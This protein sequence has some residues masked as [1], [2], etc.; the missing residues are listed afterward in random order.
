MAAKVIDLV[1]GNVTAGDLRRQ[2][3]PDKVPRSEQY[4]TVFGRA[5]DLDRIQA[6]L[7]QADFG[8]MVDLTDLEH[9]MLSLDPHLS[10]VVGKRTGWVGALDWVLDEAT[11]DNIDP[12]LATRIAADTRASIE[13]IPLFQRRLVDLAW[14][15]YDGRSALET[16]WDLAP[17]G[18]WSGKELA[19]IHP[20]RLSYGSRRELRLIDTFNRRGNFGDDG[21]ALEDFP[22]HFITY[23]PRLFNEYPEREGLAPRTLYWSFFKR[24]DWRMRMALTELFGIPWRIIETEKDATVNKEWLEEAADDAEALGE[25]TTMGLPPGAKLNIPNMGKQDGQLF[26][27]TSDDVNGEMSKLVL[28]NTGTTETD[29][30]NR[31]GMIIAKSEQ[32]VTMSGDAE[33]VSGAFQAG[34]VVPFVGLNYGMGAL[35]HAPTFRIKADTPRDQ[36]KEVERITQIVSLGI[37]VAEAE[38]REAGGARQVEEDEAFI[39][40]TGDGFKRVDPAAPPPPPPAAAPPPP[41]IEDDETLEEGGEDAAAKAAEDDLTGL[42]VQRRSLI[43]WITKR[44]GLPRSQAERAYLACEH[45]RYDELRRIPG[46]GTDSA[47]RILE[48][49][50]RVFVVSAEDGKLVPQNVALKLDAVAH[51]SANH[52]HELRV[53]DSDVESGTARSYDI[54]GAADHSHTVAIDEAGMEQ[55]K[56][57]EAITVTSTEGGEPAHVHEL[58]LVSVG[59]KTDQD[60]DDEPTGLSRVF[61]W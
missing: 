49:V 34:Y 42:E 16:H 17:G 20:R 30:G 52:G 41:P 35:D 53:G 3:I 21:F 45:G 59:A 61:T 2:L 1:N 22:G 8:L 10:G 46:L 29:Q 12:K 15:V 5:V 31:A 39:V 28:G 55:L 4:R 56:A 38:I 23:T 60:L 7:R 9:E 13:A 32:E 6:A 57:G 37:P 25:T 58:Q 43:Q 50:P 11:G 36:G 24:F 19:W 26:K 48:A 47:Q 44:T 54:K 51:V 18:R 27:L 33:G 40:G 14:G